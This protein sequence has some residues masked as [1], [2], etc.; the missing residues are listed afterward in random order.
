MRDEMILSALSHISFLVISFFARLLTSSFSRTSSF[1]HIRG[2]R[3]RPRLD[4]AVVIWE[5]RE[6]G[7]DSL[8]TPE[9]SP[10]GFF[11]P[12]DNGIGIGA[13][14][15]PPGSGAAGAEAGTSSSSSSSSS[16]RWIAKATLS[17]ARRAVTSVEFA[18]RHLG[19]RIASGSADG[20]VRVYEALD[21]MNLNHWKLEAEIEENT[22]GGG[23]G[24]M[25]DDST[26]GSDNVRRRGGMGGGMS[27]SNEG[28]GVSSLSWC[29]GRF[30]PPTLVVGYS[31]GRVSICRYDD[32]GR[33]WLE[34]MRLPGHATSGGVPRGVLDV[35]W[36]PNVGR[37]F[38]LIA[39]CG[40]DDRLLVHR[41]KR[42][43]GWGGGETQQGDGDSNV[44]GCGLV[45]EKTESLD[46]GRTNWR[47]QWNVTGTV[48]ASSG[49][50]GTVKLWKN[51]FK[52]R[53]KCVSEI[54]GDP[55]AGNA[56]ASAAAAAASSS[57]R[58]Q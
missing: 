29:T 11:E 48:L 30:E 13:N 34:A 42:G 50:G 3:S 56:V 54:V 7:F 45:Y 32:G 41:I 39:S 55:A 23:G 49:D 28:M 6:G 58:N 4:H 57:V 20:L 52:G 46:Q 31:S 47:C 25:I 15:P 26:V 21:I 38:H 51:D 35:A 22:D 40:K 24:G 10:D 33:T 17:D 27:T 53:W 18:P 1:P 44:E 14:P 16:S 37:S 8:A 12:A 43:K 19:L 2:P 9:R 5:E 36:A